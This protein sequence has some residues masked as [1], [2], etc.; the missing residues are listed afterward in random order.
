MITKRKVNTVSIQNAINKAF[1]AFGANCDVEEMASL[2]LNANGNNNLVPEIF[3]NPNLDFN[4]PCINNQFE[5]GNFYSY[6]T[7][8][9]I[10]LAKTQTVSLFGLIACPPAFGNV[11]VDEAA[12]Q[13]SVYRLYFNFNYECGIISNNTLMD[14][15]I[16]GSYNYVQSSTPN[17]VMSSFANCQTT[18]DNQNEAVLQLQAIIDT[19]TQVTTSWL[20]WVFV[21]ILILIILLIIIG[22]IV[23][24]I[25]S[26]KSIGKMPEVQIEPMEQ[27]N[28]AGNFLVERAQVLESIYPSK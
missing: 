8:E 14:F 2:N 1:I 5:T 6:V 17:Q 28:S 21:I 15:N 22:I 27:Q 18:V 11:T 12:I 4:F 10:N 3:N 26:Q 24:I 9:I 20:A 13:A 7:S 25:S 16:N 23:G 19:S